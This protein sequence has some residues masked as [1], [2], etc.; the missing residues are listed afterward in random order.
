MGQIGNLVYTSVRVDDLYD[1]CPIVDTPPWALL[2]PWEAVTREMV[3]TIVR[4]GGPFRGGPL[5]RMA[6][7]YEHAQRIAHFVV[8][9]EGWDTPIDVDVGAPW[10]RGHVYRWLIQDGNHRFYAAVLRKSPTIDTLPGG[11]LTTFNT[12]F[13]TNL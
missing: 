6:T 1:R 5:W 10:A 12:Y 8:C 13:G 9:G 4:D 2:D 3:T 7:A 11:C